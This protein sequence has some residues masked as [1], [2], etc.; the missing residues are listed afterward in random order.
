MMNRQEKVHMSKTNISTASVLPIRPEIDPSA[1]RAER[2][3]ITSLCLP[4]GLLRLLD[5]EVA[6]RR[7]PRKAEQADITLR[8]DYERR[9]GSKA[10]DAWLSL[11]LAGGRASRSA[12][13]AELIAAALAKEGQPSTP[14]RG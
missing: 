5:S 6:R 12:V 13:A 11:R 9:F 8:N 4:E 10:A 14:G 7:A 1:P 2:L 3:V